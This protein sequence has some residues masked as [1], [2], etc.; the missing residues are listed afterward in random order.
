MAL[1]ISALLTFSPAR[2]R[3][4]ARLGLVLIVL[5]VVVPVVLDPFID[6]SRAKG[7]ALW[8][9]SAI[10]G[11]TVRA[12]YSLDPLAAVALALTVAF[13]GA[14]FTTAA[15]VEPRHPSLVA[16]ILAS[17]LV[18]VALVV[19]D[20]LVAATVVLAVLGAL[21]VLALLAAAPPPATARAAGYLALGL[22]G[23]VLAALLISRHGSA[24]FALGEMPPGAVTPGAILAAT[25]GALLFAGLYPVVAWDLESGGA[26]DPGALG[27][28]LL[29]PA[30]IGATILLARLIGAGAAAPATI[31]LPD[32]GPE[33]RLVVAVLVLL[34]VAVAT[35]A[36]GRAAAR[37]VVVG[38]VLVATAAAFPALGWAHVV[39]I[40]AILTATYAGVVSLA[41][42]DRWETVRGDL[43]L[44][45][46]WTGLGTGAPL[47]IA[48]G[49]VALFARA[50]ASL[51]SSAT[52]DPHRDYIALVGSSAAFAVGALA[53]G[54]GAASAPDPA[55]ALLGVVAAAVLVA[56]EVAQVGRRFRAAS[57]PPDL[58]LASAL[59]AVLLA[60]L[61]TIVLVAV[62]A[63]VRSVVPG[64]AVLGAGHVV[65]IALAAAIT[66]VLARIVRPL[67]PYLEVAAERSGALMRALDPVP[68]AVGAFRTL[69]ASATSGSRAFALF[70]QRG[71]VWLATVLIVGLLVWAVR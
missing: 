59:V 36:R 10:G 9:W 51:A 19:T 18:T 60:A 27:G 46:L 69:E 47:G 2:S 30:G 20:D 31:P 24:G 64:P 29:M 41:L 22:Q 7:H 33:P 56:L 50:G 13:V 63:T 1:A 6:P 28:L 15:R 35:A 32:L 58:D 11:P 71:G 45:V 68:I 16:L 14:A 8:Q 54:I 42:T 53:A 61:A 48:G 26:E 70:E 39:L 65:A 34:G 66:V 40:A 57:I 43:A 44:V 4:P 52:R 55:V 17:G 49:I 62:D 5:G 25:L 3:V 21:T 38:V 12:S 23:W 37:P 67:L